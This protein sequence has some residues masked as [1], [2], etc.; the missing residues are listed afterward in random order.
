MSAS[1]PTLDQLKQQSPFDLLDPSQSDQWFGNGKF[2]KLKPGQTIVFNQS[3]QDRIYFVV[4]GEVRFL[5]NVDGDIITIQ[6]AGVG[7]LLGWVSL[8][9]AEPCEWVTAVDSTIVFALPSEDFLRLYA[10]NNNFADWFSTK[11]Q[12]HEVYRVLEASL[13]LSSQR[14]EGWR[15]KLYSFD[16]NQAFA[17]TLNPGSQFQQPDG[18]PPGFTWYISSSHVPGCPVGSEITNGQFI[19]ER[20]GFKLPYRLVGLPDSFKTTSISSSNKAQINL[21]DIEEFGKLSLQ[22]CIS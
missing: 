6:R 13:D 22:H 5:G 16:F 15:Q 18:C 21:K 3:L 11:I 14:Q 8:L 2:L 7:Q 20:Q 12:S 9:R 4:E 10:L 19:P 1:L 17:Y